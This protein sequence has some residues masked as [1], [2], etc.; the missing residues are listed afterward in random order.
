[1]HGIAYAFIGAG[2]VLML[3]MAFEQLPRDSAL[4]LGTS[5]FVIGGLVWGFAD[6]ERSAAERQDPTVSRRAP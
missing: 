3:A 6:G 5:A 4:F 1:L 2:V